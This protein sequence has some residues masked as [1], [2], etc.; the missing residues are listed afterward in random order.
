MATSPVSQLALGCV[1]AA[2]TL[3]VVILL[4]E[5]LTLINTFPERHPQFA[6]NWL[7]VTSFAA[8]VGA[9]KSYAHNNLLRVLMSSSESGHIVIGHQTV[10]NNSEAVTGTVIEGHHDA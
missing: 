4:Q 5:T 6:L 3:A 8:S 10:T 2:F 1:S 9:P 7:R